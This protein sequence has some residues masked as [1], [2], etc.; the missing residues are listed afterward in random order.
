MV[1]IKGLLKI[2]DNLDQ[3]GLHQEADETLSSIKA[4]IIEA[5]KK[6]EK[7]SFIF[8]KDHPK[9]KNNK[10]HFPINTEGRGR[11]ALSRAN[12]FT[13]APAWYSDTVK[14]FINSIVRAVHK[15]YPSIEISEKA[16][17]PGKD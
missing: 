3:V 10:D 7:G 14:E 2:A 13:K 11:N 9:V 5:A 16:K 8:P 1:M 4:I 17:K 6:K 12:A 15:K